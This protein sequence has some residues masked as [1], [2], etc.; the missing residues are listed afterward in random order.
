M[1]NSWTVELEEDET[2]GELVLPFP[3]ELLSQMGWAPGTEL[4]WEDNN[5]GSFSI[6]Q[7]KEKT[8]E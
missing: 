2:T 1:P 8:D 4:W 5:D 6:K 3:P 7:K